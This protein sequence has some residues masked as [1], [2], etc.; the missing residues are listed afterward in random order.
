[1]HKNTFRD[2][3]I[4][5]SHVFYASYSAGRPCEALKAFLLFISNVSKACEIKNSLSSVESACKGMM[6]Y[7]P[8]L[9]SV[10]SLWE[11]QFEAFELIKTRPSFY[12]NIIVNQ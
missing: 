8:F 5:T 7:G 3:T 11:Q 4:A 6:G 2:A 9:F 12:I 10:D 1:M